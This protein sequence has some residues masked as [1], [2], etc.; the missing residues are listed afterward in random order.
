MQKSSSIESS[1]MATYQ[2]PNAGL[3][4][5]ADAAAEAESSQSDNESETHFSTRDRTSAPSDT[6]TELRQVMTEM[7]AFFSRQMEC[8]TRRMESFEQR[9]TS[10]HTS[11]SR[12]ST[13]HTSSRSRVSPYQPP[14]LWAD[15]PLNEPL[16]QGPIVWPDEDDDEIDGNDAA[17]TADT[18]DS[19][20]CALHKVSK[21]TAS[22]LGEAFS[23]PVANSTRR[24]WRMTYGMPALDATKSPKLDT[25]IR[26]QIP[27][28]AKEADRSLG[29]L[30][31]LLLDAVGPLAH[32]LEQQRAGR[33]TPDSAVEAVT[34]AVRFLGNAQANV[35]SERRK[36]IVGHLN[37]DLRL[38]V[39]ETERFTSSAP[40]LFGRD[41]E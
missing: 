39:E 31:A 12:D 9:Y 32:V 28:D 26:P 35:S 7:S 5:L 15:R 27:K 41:F 24:R 1:E 4:V 40:Y 2:D 19:D 14:R 20:G 34:Q 13:A 10:S 25:M 33:L 6:A 11:R 18:D 8:L 22:L 37:K 21:D 30:Q 23:K 17:E 29:R 16:P 36:K 3:Y 38:L